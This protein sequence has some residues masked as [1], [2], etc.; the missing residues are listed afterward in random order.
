M[1][2]QTKLAY[3]H[4]IRQPTHFD[5]GGI[6]RIPEI[7]WAS[8]V[9]KVTSTADHLRIQGLVDQNQNKHLDEAKSIT[10]NATPRLGFHMT[11]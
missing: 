8:Q 2:C 3:A 6:Q 4:A 11:C 10:Q 1:V 7:I 9:T 5:C